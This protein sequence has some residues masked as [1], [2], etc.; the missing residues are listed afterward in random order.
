M[1]HK[2]FSIVGRMMHL[3][4]GLGPLAVMAALAAVVARIERPR[5]GHG[6]GRV[7]TV[8]AVAS[9]LLLAA[10]SLV[11]E[12]MD[13]TMW[14]V[15]P[16]AVVSAVGALVAVWG[17]RQLWSAAVA[18]IPTLLSIPFI[19]WTIYNLA[20]GPGDGSGFEGIV[21]LLSYPFFG[22]PA[23]VVG[24]STA[25]TQVLRDRNRADVVA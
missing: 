5:A 4:F 21:Y 6:W 22:L 15:V 23:L 14:E 12:S 17:A 3:M 25:L 7:L 8:G 18:Y 20:T 9:V 19:F 13:D 11:P 16:G 24:L 1:L 2:E 10:M